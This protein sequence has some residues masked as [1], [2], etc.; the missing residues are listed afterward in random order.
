MRRI[1]SL[2]LSALVAVALGVTTGTA[3]GAKPPAFEKPPR[4]VLSSHGT[5]D[6]A[7]RGS[8]C[9]AQEDGGVV[10]AESAEPVLPT[11]RFVRVH[12][13]SVVEVDLRA[14]AESLS[15]RRKGSG[16]NA[17]RKTYAPACRWDDEGR[18]WRFQVPEKERRSRG[19]ALV[20]DYT[21]GDGIFGIRLEFHRH[22]ASSPKRA[23]NQPDLLEGLE[24][25]LADDRC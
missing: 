24:D 18:L 10:C 5:T 4:P 2:R 21:K 25:L 13:G 19:V 17:S 20:V 16:G 11:R 9:W 22:P 1:V 12:R 3:F 15:V 8:Y 23:A 7:K 6:K 14:P